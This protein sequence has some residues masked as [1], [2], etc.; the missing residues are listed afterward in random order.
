MATVIVTASEISKTTN[1]ISFS[2]TCDNYLNG[3]VTTYVYAG[4]TFMGSFATTN[5]GLQTRTYTKSGLSAGTSYYAYGD[6]YGT[7][8]G[9]YYAS[10]GVTI[11]TDA[12]PPS[13]P[14]FP[15]FFPYFPPFFPFFPPL[16]T[17]PPGWSG[18]STDVVLA[19]AMESIAYSDGVAATDATSYA[20]ASG[21]LP[22]GLSLNTSTGAI[23]GTPADGTAGTY[24]LTITATGA[25]GSTTSSTITLVVVKETGQLFV[26]NSGSSQ[27]VKGTMNTFTDVG[28]TPTAAKNTVYIYNSTSSQW[29]I[30]QG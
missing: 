30:S 14:Y 28:G 1:S 13:F 5:Y 9:T 21:S 10:G 3:S 26:Y 16:F 7:S 12:P 29:E 23:T 25:G 2:I 19:N 8:S 11:T 20:I 22:S 15:P 6:A 18:G 4:G 17:P 27:W 24:N